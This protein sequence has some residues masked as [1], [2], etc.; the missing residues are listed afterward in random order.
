[1]YQ[2]RAAWT[3]CQS[4]RE[5]LQIL[6]LVMRLSMTLAM[7]SEIPGLA[8]QA[9]QL[10]GLSLDQ[11]DAETVRLLELVPQTA[12]QLEMARQNLRTSIRTQLTEQ[13][14]IAILV[15][16]II[17]LGGSYLFLTL[18]DFGESYYRICVGMAVRSPN[19]LRDAGSGYIMSI[20]ALLVL[21][22]CA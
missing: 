17:S 16:T 13:D 19:V 1:M 10:A 18:P 22:H 9:I 5:H 7:V 21:Y 4:P 3:H 11:S 12:S 2:I 8:S 20:M 6:R 15:N 14:E